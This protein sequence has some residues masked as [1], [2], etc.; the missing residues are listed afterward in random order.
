M[1]RLQRFALIAAAPALAALVVAAGCTNKPTEA[2][3]GPSGPAGT[4]S[5]S[6]SGSG[7]GQLTALEAKDT[8][9]LTGKVTYDGKPPEPMSL[10]SR[11]EAVPADKAHCQKGPKVD[12]TWVVGPNNGVANVVVWLRPPKGKFFDIPAKLRERKDTVVMDQPYCAFEPHVMTLFPSYYDG[13]A[14]RQKPTG[15]KFVVKNSAPMNHNTAWS[16]NVNPGDNKL[17]KSKENL[18]IA[19]KPS[20]DRK[21]GEEL[22]S[23]KC[24]LHKWMTAYAWV[25]DQPYFAK[26]DKD[27]VYKIENVP[28]G[29]EVELAYWHES[30]GNQPKTEKITLNAGE[31][32][33]DFTVKAK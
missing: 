24:D 2:P 3:A 11:F 14:K 21:V 8:G 32:K 26:T 17:V 16:G 28:A 15:E 13:S 29:A 9:T 20:A 19:L 25:F 12:E 23:F 6:G 22:V 10:E 33:K 4:Q 31:N 7:G 5:S 30:F 18:D 27:G 1:M